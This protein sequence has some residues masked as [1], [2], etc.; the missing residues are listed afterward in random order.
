MRRFSEPLL[1]QQEEDK[2]T[3]LESWP[4]LSETGQTT[5][6]SKVKIVYFIYVLIFKASPPVCSACEI[7]RVKK[8]FAYFFRSDVLQNSVAKK[9]AVVEIPPATS[10][11]NIKTTPRKKGIVF[12]SLRSNEY[13][14]LRA[15][16]TNKWQPRRLLSNH[17]YRIYSRKAQ[18]I[19]LC[20]LYLNYISLL[21]CC[22]YK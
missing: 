14:D 16:H 18:S 7:V 22:G 11:E 6:E 9:E 3:D 2:L 13:Y 5:D 12:H 20:L 4:S 15:S 21:P 1:R 8:I 10:E 17:M 19:R